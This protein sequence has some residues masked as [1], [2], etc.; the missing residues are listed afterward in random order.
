MWEA[1][2]RP[3]ALPVKNK[4]S[5]GGGWGEPQKLPGLVLFLRVFKGF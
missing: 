3:P 4:V 1:G 5:A 2:A